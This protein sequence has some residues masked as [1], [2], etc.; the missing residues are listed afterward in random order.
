MGNPPPPAINAS[1]ARVGIRIFEA[2]AAGQSPRTIGA[3][4]MREGI[5]GPRSPRAGLM[6]LSVVRLI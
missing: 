4:L 3:T 6:V 5:G 1:Q 2:F